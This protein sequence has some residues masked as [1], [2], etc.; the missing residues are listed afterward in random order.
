MKKLEDFLMPTQKELFSKLSGMY[1]GRTMTCKNSYILVRGE[2]PIMLVAHLDTVHK[3]PVKH[4][5]KTQN[6]G[7]L[8][9][10]QGIGGDDR[11]G[12]Y[13]LT[14]VH[15]QSA[16]K[17]WLLFTSFTATYAQKSQN[18]DFAHVCLGF[19]T[20]EQR[21]NTSRRQRVNSSYSV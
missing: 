1:K 13:A 14:A 18:S 7:I 8:M 12:V 15:E 10:P 16:V 4:I 5:C 21:E 19:I 6:G 11:C 20:Q 3:T 2:A 9:S 17:P